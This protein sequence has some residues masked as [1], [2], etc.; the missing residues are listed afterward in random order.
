MRLRV[1]A[2][3]LI[4]PATL[5]AGPAPAAAQAVDPAHRARALELAK[6][7][8]PR[9]LVLSA[10]M[11]QTDKHFVSVL[12]GTPEGKEM[13]AAYPGILDAM[14][15]GAR[16]ELVTAMEAMIPQM[17][18]SF[19]DLLA[20]RLTLAEME[21]METFYR[22]PTGRKMLQGAMGAID[23]K[24][25]FTEA[26]R[27]EDVTIGSADINKVQAQAVRGAVASVDASDMAALE[28]FNRSG[29]AMKI[30]S[31]TPD[32]QKIML[33]QA[34]SRDPASEARMEAAMMAAMQAH[35]A[36]AEAK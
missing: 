2:A 4:A 26:A 27:Q 20:A 34:N 33:E 9:E 17:W 21:A 31:L 29:A 35:I 8:Q 12:G 15:K 24:G 6:L 16:G 28:A 3:L 10:V 1:A 7:T 13:E 30:V 22:T 19:A 18:D 11:A 23:M 32:F 14:Y 5:I 25:L 36:K